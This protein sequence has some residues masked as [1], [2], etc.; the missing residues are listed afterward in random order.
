MGLGRS[1]PD[2]QKVRLTAGH[3]PL[4]EPTAIGRAYIFG[5]PSLHCAQ[6]R[7]ATGEI[8]A[9]YGRVGDYPGRAL[10]TAVEQVHA[11]GLLT[12]TVRP[13]PLVS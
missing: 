4:D 5:T 6:H 1:L 10:R 8:W 13:R 9:L 3:A 11:K 2:F 7:Q 12:L